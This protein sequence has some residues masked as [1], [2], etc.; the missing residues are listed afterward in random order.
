MAVE[1]MRFINIVGPKNSL[2]EFV[3]T[4]L[5]KRDIELVNS[6]SILDDVKGITPYIVENPYTHLLKSAKEALAKLGIEVNE[7][8]LDLYNEN[9][10]SDLEMTEDYMDEVNK[11]LKEWDDYRKQVEKDLDKKRKIKKQLLL[12]QDL[13]VEI[14]KFFHFNFIKFRF[15]SL[16]KYNFDK[17]D[18]YTE[19]V[20]VIVIEVFQ[21]EDQVY[22]MYFSPEESHEKVDSLFS[23][24]YFHRIFI[25]GE[26]E[27]HPKEALIKVENDITVL[28]RKLEDLAKMVSNYATD[29]VEQLKKI[30]YSANKYYQVFHV[31][32]YAAHSKEIFCLHGWISESELEDFRDELDKSS[33][34][35][36]VVEEPEDVP[37]LKPPTKLKNNPIFRPFQELVNMYGTPSYNEF[38]PTPFVAI[39]YMLFFGMMFGD[40]GQGFILALLGYSAF[41]KSG[42]MLGKVIMMTGFSSM[43]FGLVYGSIFGIEEIGHTRIPHLITPMEDQYLILG[44]GIGIGVLLIII[45][46]LINIY[47]ALRN[48][49]YGKVLFDK[50]G[51]VGL[52]FYLALL[53]VVGGIVAN[54]Q[55]YSNPL[56]IILFL[57][58]PIIILFFSHPLMKYVNHAKDVFPKEKGGFIV[59]AFFEVV[60]ILLS[61]LSNTLSFVRIGAFAL[62]HVG[63][64]MAVKTLGEMTGEIGGIIIF[65]VGNIIII[66][67]EGLIVF[68]Q[69]LRLEYYEMFSRFYEGDGREI[70][71][72][73]IK[74]ESEV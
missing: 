64:F 20:D 60:E 21:E 71:P 2:D 10:I 38:D 8:D 54:Y 50:N 6:M 35:S 46:M 27:G 3:S 30:Y 19:N 67:L 57:I 62:N 39:T 13:D 59:E 68:I 22:I 23:S 25:S 41:K 43:I 11:K 36:Y 7:K 42:I 66:G 51:V 14:D 33:T 29:H 5:V 12:L 15:G 55:F 63:L 74:Y 61:I 44:I 58:V 1:K 24:L 53:G 45:A 65:I 4:C 17:L 69:G 40:V 47:N 32:K 9:C 16:P 48:K 72:F 70:N 28:E 49:N 26:V 56:Y 34:I 31:R 73:K 18:H 52:V 37:K